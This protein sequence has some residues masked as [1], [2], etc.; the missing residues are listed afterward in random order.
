MSTADYVTMRTQMSMSTA[1]YVTMGPQI[2]YHK[3][4][5]KRHTD[6]IKIK[7]TYQFE[8]NRIIV[9]AAEDCDVIKNIWLSNIDNICMV[10]IFVIGDYIDPETITINSPEIYYKNEVILLTKINNKVLKIF[11]KDSQYKDTQF[12]KLPIFEN[13]LMTQ[14]L[15][16]KNRKLLIVIDTYDNSIQHSITIKRSLVNDCEEAKLIG[17][18]SNQFLVKK[19]VTFQYDIKIGE[20]ILNTEFIENAIAYF[21]INSDKNTHKNM[22]ISLKCNMANKTIL[23]D[24][25]ETSQDPEYNNL[26]DDDFDTYIFDSFDNL[27][28][29][30]KS[31][32]Q[33]IGVLDMKEGSHIIINSQIDTKIEITYAIFIVFRYDYGVY[34]EKQCYEEPKIMPN[35]G[36]NIDDHLSKEKNSTSCMNSICSLI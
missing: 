1:D 28:Q 36:D 22:K 15:A 4:T 27:N 18:R 11:N 29:H 26:V 21:I 7:N 5:Y 33:P 13:G 9:P 17:M 19:L 23:H 20:N 2:T 30:I 8:N 25:H 32:T 31:E 10:S 24:M 6:M 3:S 16:I 14:Q 35:M 12:G 34:I